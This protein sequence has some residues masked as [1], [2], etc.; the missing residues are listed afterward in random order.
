MIFF[1]QSFLL[2]PIMFFA[3]VKGIDPCHFILGQAE[4][5]NFRIFPDM[6]GITGTGDDHHALLQI[7]S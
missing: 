5:V 1:S 6:V 3:P 4:M 7:P 2:I